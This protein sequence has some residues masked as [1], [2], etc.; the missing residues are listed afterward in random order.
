MSFAYKR[1]SSLGTSH[2]PS[3]YMAEIVSRSSTHT[4]TKYF[5]R[6][7]TGLEIQKQLLKWRE[8]GH[9]SKITG[10]PS[11]QIVPSF[12]ARIS[13]CFAYMEASVDE[14]GNC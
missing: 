14:S 11:R 5:V 3:A 7:N 10:Q 4:H 8:S 12:A 6:N 9:I 2:D 13:A 1:I